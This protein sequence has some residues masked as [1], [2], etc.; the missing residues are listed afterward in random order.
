MKRPLP[1]TPEWLDPFS[2]GKIPP[3]NREIEIAVLGA[4]LIESQAFQSIRHLLSEDMFYVD[5][6]SKI[7][8]AFDALHLLGTPIDM[9]SVTEQLRKHGTLDLVGGHFYV[10]ELPNSVGSAAHILSWAWQIKYKWYLRETI[11]IATRVAQLSYEDGADMQ[12]VEWFYTSAFENLKMKMLAGADIS[13]DEVFDTYLHTLKKQMDSGNVISGLPSGYY[14]LDRITGGFREGELI[15][16]GARPAMGK[17][18]FMLQL[19]LNNVYRSKKRVMA[20]SLEMTFQMLLHRL[21]ANRLTMD[22]M[23]LQNGQISRIDYSNVMAEIMS[24]KSE[25]NLLINDTYMDVDELCS[26]AT[27]AHTQSPLSAIYVD[28]LQLCGVPSHRLREG[29]EQQVAYIARSLA[30]LAKKLR[31]P[32][33]AL[34]QLARA[35]EHN[36]NKEPTLKDL[37]ESGEIEQSARIVMFLHRPEY[38]GITKDSE[39]T[40]LRGLVKVIVAKNNNGTICLDGIPLRLDLPTQKFYDFQRSDDLVDYARLPKTKVTATDDTPF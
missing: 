25:T 19:M 10:S 15:V 22:G 27:L 1:T 4:C 24:L 33:I 3:Q 29:R 2:F 30:T 6:H 37:R 14:D 34:A 18:A 16:V 35:T 20:F 12:E 31:I 26:R 13:Y 11:K 5:E 40:D 7:W 28:Y 32:V 8:A 36:T 39:G 38:Y 17:T 9:L 21:V 23:K